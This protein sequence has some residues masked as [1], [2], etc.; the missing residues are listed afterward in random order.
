MNEIENIVYNLK[1]KFTNYYAYS[2]NDIDFK[3]LHNEF[4]YVLG[5]N[6]KRLEF[7]ID[8]DCS[9][10]FTSRLYI[11]TSDLKNYVITNIFNCGTF[12]IGEPVELHG[13]NFKE[14]FDSSFEDMSD[15]MRDVL[16]MDEME[17]MI[18]EEVDPKE[19][20]T[21]V[22]I[23]LKLGDTLYNILAVYLEKSEK[24]NKK[25]YKIEIVNRI[26]ENRKI[27][28]EDFEDNLNTMEMKNKLLEDIRYV[29][30]IETPITFEG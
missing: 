5:D 11:K 14:N 9:D 18:E 19:A 29:G 10:I 12:Y 1:N 30:N 8:Y 25:V 22:D 7:I 16:G 28:Y 6:F 20:K 23:L 24:D 21:F 17:D 2:I 3:K 4:K 27:V 13:V 15:E 26:D